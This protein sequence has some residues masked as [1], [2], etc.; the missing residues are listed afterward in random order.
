MH[1]KK[2]MDEVHEVVEE[3]R[4]QVH[5]VVDKPR[6]EVELQVLETFCR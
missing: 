6:K 4:E 1:D 5:D 2:N 3:P